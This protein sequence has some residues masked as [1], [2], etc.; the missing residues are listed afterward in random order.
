MSLAVLPL[1]LLI[2]IFGYL[3][4]C[5]IL[6]MR[7]TCK[8]LCLA[9]SVRIVWVDALHRMCIDNEV[10]RPSFSVSTMSI[11]Q[12][13]HAATAPRRFITSTIRHS[14]KY[15]TSE[16]RPSYHIQYIAPSVSPELV[17]PRALY[18]VPGGRYLISVGR[19]WMAVWD[20][21]C[22]SDLDAGS[23]DIGRQ[24]AVR[25][26][27]YDRLFLVHSTPDGLGLR[28]FILGTDESDSSAKAMF[29]A[30]LMHCRCIFH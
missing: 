22:T 18:L 24:L 2:V 30:F 23:T 17:A 7:K 15:G 9:T 29:V 26:V 10:F 28:I 14:E 16:I 27:N 12:L 8:A 1:D 25:V 11:S 19:H 21:S 4:P 5:D 3:H 6:N 13:E 20:L